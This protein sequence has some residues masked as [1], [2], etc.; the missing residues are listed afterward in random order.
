MFSKIKHTLSQNLLNIPG[1][2]TNR[3]I[4]VIESDDWGSVRMPSKE[5]YNSFIKAGIPLNKCPYNRFDSLASEKDLEN[6]FSVLVK[7]KDYK[8]NHPIITANTVVANPDFEKISGSGFREYFYEPFTVTLK[9]YPEHAN[10]IKYW[11]DGI[12]AGLFHPQFH[13]REHV[14]IIL[15]LKLLREKHPIFLNAFENGFWGIG[16]SVVKLRENINIQATFDA[17]DISEIELHK[18]QIHEG[19]KLFYEI[20]WYKSKSFIANNFIWH[21]G[22]NTEL[23][24]NGV[25]TIQGMKYQLLPRLGKTNRSRIRHYVGE[26]NS[27]KQVFLIRNCSFEPSENP[28]IDNVNSCLKQINNAFFWKKPAIISAHRVNFIGF[29]EPSNSERNLKLLEL[30]LKA[31]LLKWPDVEFITSDILGEIIKN[32]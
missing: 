21:T 17:Q 7:F 15:W 18:T 14:N 23:I 20:F 16:P 28:H 32:G 1:W 19:L 22:L 13:G 27:Y 24:Q 10:A 8:G 31:I 9:R 12:A 11:K 25:N 3:K 30:L 2:R 5:V 6:L 4:V 26:A 29:I